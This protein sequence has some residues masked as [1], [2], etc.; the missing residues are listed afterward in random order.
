MAKK[1]VNIGTSANKGNGDPLRTAF[2]KINDNFDEIYGAIG[3]D[4]SIFNPLSVDSHILPDTDNTRDLGSPAKRWRDVFVAPGSLY[5]G[6]IKLSAGDGVL[7]VQQVTDAGLV[8]EAPVPGSPG[9]VTT[10]RLS[11]GTHE[12][13]LESNGTLSLN[14]NPFTGS[15]GVSISDFGIGF[16]NTLDSGKITTSKL[17][18]KNPNPGLNNQYTLEVTDG[19][20]V[21][22]PDGSIINGATLKSVAG[23]YAGITAG[24]ASPAGKDEDSWMWV[25]SNGAFIATDYSDNAYTWTFNNS[26]DLTFPSGGKVIGD[27]QDGT[28]LQANPG[29]DGYAGLSSLNG[30]SWMWTANDGG[31]YISSSDGATVKS[32]SFNTDGTTSF[33]NNA[34]TTS[35]TPL[36]IQTKLPATYGPFYTAYFESGNGSVNGVHPGTYAGY[37][38]ITTVNINNDGTYSVSGYPESIQNG[39]NPTYTISGVDLG[40]TSPAN[41]CLLTVTTVN[42]IITNVVVSGTALLPKWTFGTDGVLELPESGD[43]VDSNGDSVLGGTADTGNIEFRNDS[44]NDINGILITNNSLTVAATASI[45]IPANTGGPI[46]INNVEKSTESNAIDVVDDFTAY[47]TLVD[48]T[49]T[50]RDW[51]QR[52]AEQIEVNLFVDTLSPAYTL[53]TGLALDRAAVVTYLDNAGDPQTFTSVVSQQFTS[54]G[55]GDPSN[56]WVR[57]SGRIDGTLPADVN[58]LALSISSV[59]FPVDIITNKNW[60]F[61][62]DG[63]L[64]LP[65]GGAINNTD[66]IVLVTD[67]GTL[68]MGTNMEVPGVA[69]HFHIAFDGSNSNPPAGDLFLGD[70]NNYVKLPGYEL[71]PTAQ[72]GVEIGTDN[73]SLGPQNIEVSTVDELV[74]PGG[75][76]RFFIGHET[77]PNLGSSVSVGDTVTT[78]WGTPITATITAVVEQPGLWWIIAVAQDI[79]AGFSGGD[80]VSFGTSGDSH[81]WRFGTDGSLTLPTGGHIGPSGGK[82]EGTTYGGA[83]DH[84]VSLTSYYDSG[85]YSSCVTAYAD[86]TLYITAYN[87]GGPNPAKIW[88]FANDGSLTFPDGSIQTTAYTGSGAVGTFFV[89]VNDDGTVSKSTDG[90]SWTAGADQG[91]DINRVATNGVT[92]AMIQSDQLSWTTFAGLEASTYLSGSSST[93]DQIGGQ[94]IDWN[95]IDYAGG[96]FVAVGSYDPTGS[97]FDQGVYGYST[98]GRSW[99]FKTVD[100]TVVEFFGNDPVDSNWQ[101]SDVDYNGVGW[102]FSVSDGEGGGANGGGVYITDLTATVTSARCFSMN[103]TYK[104]AWN[105]SA[106]YMEGDESIAGVN[107]NLD[108]R[109]GTFAGPIDPW[110]TS[111][112]DLGIEGGGTVET[113][114]GN[115]YLAVSDSDGHVAWSD[116]N[117]QTWQI[118]TPIPY[119][120]TIS[121][122]TQASPAVVTSSGNYG[123]SGEKVVISGSSVSGYNGTFYWKSADNSL[124]T[125]QILDTPFDTSGLAPFT[126]TATLTWSNGQY[127]DAMDY[128]NGYFYIGNDDEQIARTTNFVSWTIVDDQT[129]DFEYWNDIAGFVGTGGTDNTLVNRSHTV[130]LEADGTLTLPQGGAISETEVNSSHSILLTPYAD[131]QYNPDMAVRIYPTFND[132]DHIH[133]TAGNPST[134]D[135]FLGDDN[136]YVKIEQNAGNIVIGTNN[137]THNWTF[138]TDGALTIPDAGIKG[139]PSGINSIDLSWELIL[140]SGK[141]IK[142]NPGAGGVVSPTFFAFNSDASGGGIGLPAGSS[143]DDRLDG[144]IISGAGETRVNRFYAKVSN[145]LYETVDAG[146]TYR[147]INQAGTWSLDVVGDSNPRYTSTN[148]LTWTGGI[149]PAPT[150]EL[151]TRA[152]TLTVGTGNTWRFGGDGDLIIP[153]TGDIVRDGTSIFASSTALPIVTITNANYNQ[154]DQPVAPATQTT[155]GAVVFT[156]TSPVALT[157]TG[158]L[159]VSGSNDKG[160]TIVAGGTSTGS[161]TLVF[162]MGGYNSIYTVMAF[163]TTANGTSYSAPVAGNGGYVCFPAGT[164]ITLSNGTKKA[165]EDIGYDDHILVWNFDLGEYASAKPIWIKASETA[166]EYNVLT[167]SDGSVLKTVGN[168]HIFNKQAERFTHTMTADTPIGTVTV[169]EQGEEITLVSAEVVKESVEFYNVWTEYHLNMF[170]QGVLTSN[171]FNNTYPIVGMKF[172]KGNT[173]LRDLAE[174]NGIDPKWI[175]GLR[176]QEQ[177]PEHTAEYIKWYVSERLEKLRVDSV[178]MV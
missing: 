11:S 147:L 96:Y 102:M 93:R 146:I 145:T 22:L 50:I 26:G 53:L 126:G 138:G 51:S 37:F 57:V 129:N 156:V 42:D 168:H 166:T 116:D 152:T 117:G 73:R 86:G 165:I 157:A 111:I 114:G 140:N 119:T 169:N 128:I 38:S 5:I 33:P 112:Q 14:G 132:D 58:T 83:N 35:N 160:G 74:P 90:V 88:E 62:T 56:N 172:V 158:L 135:L 19:G 52:N 68:A 6:D 3:A 20:V 104:A 113:A 162:D 171:R 98:D 46:T 36:T 10:D 164:M 109:N 78:S 125:D 122:I 167:F 16:V 55:Q 137:D 159:L 150:G 115:G 103:I 24:P 141:T 175:Q 15:G 153:D 107:A 100:Q 64:T 41:D 43:I 44:M 7:T 91:A 151:T 2:G 45:G 99:T 59:D 144:V 142:I 124:Y 39:T 29:N 1:T 25:E 139:G 80:T 75:V 177:A 27:S 12:F 97:S 101:F 47:V 85:L 67:R 130:S 69:G 72:F 87:D 54:T 95:Q 23:N 176:L 77:Y 9:V 123:E 148:L 66:G 161:Q 8:T 178:E 79:T 17:Y 89:V 154:F 21:V 174:F 120:I 108:P 65:A 4:G 133:I 127:I 136:Q 163:A 40:G 121:A 105:G 92:V 13:V 63:N 76:W 106:W 131:P 71:N 155:E 18:N 48:G 173:E 61:G 32:W 49:T 143:F 70:D 118:V 82:G 81:T 30:N 84:L 94:N 134:V 170:A 34:I 149:S 60:T 31:A 28:Y 110:S